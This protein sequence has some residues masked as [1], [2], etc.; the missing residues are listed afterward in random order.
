MTCITKLLQTQY[1]L[2]FGATRAIK[3]MFWL[4]A[5]IFCDYSVI[6][7]SPKSLNKNIVYHESNQSPFKAGNKHNSSLHR[8]KQ[9]LAYWSLWLQLR[10]YLYLCWKSTEFKLIMLVRVPL[11]SQTET[12]WN[13]IYA[14]AHFLKLKFD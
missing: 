4:F 6:V 7:P 12:R 14:V 3:S 5:K 9:C 13:H 11:Y 2:L 8:K 10:L 1:T